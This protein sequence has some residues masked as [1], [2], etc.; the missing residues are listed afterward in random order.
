MALNVRSRGAPRSHLVCRTSQPSSRVRRFYHQR[1]LGLV[2]AG[3]RVEFW[4]ACWNPQALR[5]SP[6]RDCG[7]GPD[8]VRVTLRLVYQS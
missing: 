3:P 6:A 5:A 7:E 1:A 8:G 4:R 2:L